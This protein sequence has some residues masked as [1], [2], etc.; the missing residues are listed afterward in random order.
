MSTGMGGRAGE[1]GER[2]MRS[3]AQTIH[4]EKPSID[5]MDQLAVHGTLT[6]RR[7]EI[8]GNGIISQEYID[9]QYRLAA[10]RRGDI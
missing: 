8:D 7:H 6:T 9:L 10:L 2:A 3:S 4:C 5:T 1:R